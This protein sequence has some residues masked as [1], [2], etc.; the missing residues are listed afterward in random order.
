[1]LTNMLFSVVV[2]E[3]STSTNPLGL[4]SHWCSLWHTFTFHLGW[5]DQIIKEGEL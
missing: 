1:M 2:C 3:R 4:G 5:E